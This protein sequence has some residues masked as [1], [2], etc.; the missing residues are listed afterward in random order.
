M[1]VTDAR[2]RILSLCAR[3]SA[4]GADIVESDS[5]LIPWSSD[6]AT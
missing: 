4:D 5:R 2:A 3:L 6:R 1:K